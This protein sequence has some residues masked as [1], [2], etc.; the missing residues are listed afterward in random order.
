M[1]G[2][3]TMFDITARSLV[4]IKEFSGLPEEELIL[5]PGTVLQVVDIY[6]AGNDLVMIQLKEKEPFTAMMD[7]THPGLAKSADTATEIT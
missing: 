2:K 6:D 4:S 3:R 1:T 7:F 5:L